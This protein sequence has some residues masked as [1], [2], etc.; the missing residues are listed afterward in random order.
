MPKN[1]HEAIKLAIVDDDPVIIESLS[2]L[3]QPV[4]DV[5]IVL[6]V[7]TVESLLAWIKDSSALD[8]LLLDISLPGIS[9][10]DGIPKIKSIRPN[11]DIIILTTF[12]D[13]DKIFSSLRAGACSYLSKQTPLQEILHAIYTVRA[14]G[15]SMSPSIARKIAN[16]YAPKTTSSHQL[17]DRQL[18]I[19]DKIVEG[20]SYKMVASELY[21]S[22][23]TVRSHIKNI[24]N[25]LNINSKG[26]LI[27]KSFDR[28]I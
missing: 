11:L 20:K 17:T 4:H 15:S 22:I 24:Y 5:Q 28:E 7:S 6:A 27:R 26:E 18:E 16:Y 25:T 8:I 3:F 12:E 10:I 19:I 14:G 13:T 1:F 2:D 23:D 9:G 21:I